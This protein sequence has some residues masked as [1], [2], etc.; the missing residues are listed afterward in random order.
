M[1]AQDLYCIIMRVRKIKALNILSGI[2]SVKTQSKM[3]FEESE[4]EQLERYRQLAL[5]SS[6][7]FWQTNETFH[8]TFMSDSVERITGHTKDS[9]IGV[10]RFDLAS[11]K[12]KKSQSWK[13]HVEQIRRHEPIKNFKYE[14]ISATEK[15][16]CLCVNAVPLF[17]K[18][19]HFRGYLGTTSDIS[20]LI[21]ATEEAERAHIKL[22]AKTVAL[23]KAKLIA[24]R[25]ARTDVLTGL[26]NR[27]SFFENAKVIEDQ[28][29]RYDHHYSIIMLDIDFFKSINDNYG[30][31][32]GDTVLKAVAAA[33][34]D[35]TRISDISGRIG[36]EEFGIILPESSAASAVNMA[37]RLRHA[38]SVISI[39][40]NQTAVTLTASFGVAEYLTDHQSIDEVIAQADKALYLAKQQ[41]RDRVIFVSA[42]K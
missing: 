13:N 33:I 7:W 17:D 41:G 42:D 12:T 25:M 3:T 36:G 1:Y 16:F 22:Q 39:P 19:G 24:E 40:F 28:S 5:I 34:N 8:I 31:A 4:H 38:I 14:H 9:Y 6:D 15:T 20:E 26:S 32:V 21:M 10:S 35:C 37:E 29:R 27:R 2:V 23:E 11:E 18:D 30:H